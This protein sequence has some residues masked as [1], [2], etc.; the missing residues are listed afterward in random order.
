MGVYEFD[1][2]GIRLIIITRKSELYF[3]NY[4]ENYS[5]NRATWLGKC[6]FKLTTVSIHDDPDLSNERV[7]NEWVSDYYKIDGNKF[8]YRNYNKGEMTNF[9]YI[10]KK[11]SKIPAKFKSM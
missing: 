8:Y 2:Y 7:G 6:K 1:D 9:G 5:V 4:P 10:I 3:R 11:T